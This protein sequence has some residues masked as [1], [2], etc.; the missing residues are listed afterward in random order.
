M[1]AQYTG[2]TI[3]LFYSGGADALVTPF[4]C[5]RFSA[6]GSAPWRA[7]SGSMDVPASAG[8]SRAHFQRRAHTCAYTRNEQGLKRGQNHGIQG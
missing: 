5:A 2:G 1:S 6:G 8:Q 3:T 7:N 4:A